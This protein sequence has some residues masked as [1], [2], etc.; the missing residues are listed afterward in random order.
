ME[1]LDLFKNSKGKIAEHQLIIVGV[2]PMIRELTSNPRTIF[3]ILNTPEKD[4]TTKDDQLLITIIY[5]SESEAF[6]Q[7]LFYSK[8][9]NK[10]KLDYDKLLT[11][12]SR[13][14]GGKK[15]KKNTAGFVEDILR[16]CSAERPE[17]L[18]SMKKRIILRQ[19]NLRHFANLIF[20]DDVIRYC[21]TTLSLPDISMYRSIT[22]EDDPD[23]FVQLKQYIDYLM[24]KNLGGKYLSKQDDELIELYD[25]DNVPRGI[26]PRKAFYTTNYQRY[27]VWAFIFNR[28]GELLLQQRSPY[29]KD[30][31]NLWDKSAGGHVDLKDSSTIITAKRELVEELFLPEAEFSKY[32]KAELGDIVDFGEWNIDKRPEK[33]FR[34][35]FEG[36]ASADWVVFRPADKDEDGEPMTIK[37][38][39]PRLMHV[40]DLDEALGKPIPLLDEYNNPIKLPNGSIQYKEH[41]ETWYTRFLSD[42]FLFVAPANY[43]ETQEDLDEL[44]AVAEKKGAQSAHK[45]MAIEDLIEDVEANPE[46][47]TDDMVYMCSEKKWLLVEFSES[48][49]YIFNNQ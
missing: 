3:D 4:G 10:E 7:S 25:L 31:R 49:R 29:T 27:S 33:N 36:L 11:Y 18:D 19:N 17:I 12:R 40:Q 39:S 15:G 8:K 21:F 2:N 20:A 6:N 32:M 22:Q 43:I 13:L 26:Y 46:K 24:D 23:L 30:N 5:E 48:I 38:K 16:F 14:T 42:V 1:L 35:E 44:M 34:Q 28:K 47:Y 37:R 45:L 41:T 9:T